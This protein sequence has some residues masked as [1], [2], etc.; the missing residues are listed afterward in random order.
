MNLTLKEV[1]VS[2][3]LWLFCDLM[4]LQI[5]DHTWL[6]NSLIISNQLWNIHRNYIKKSFYKEHPKSINLHH[7]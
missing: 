1:F 6:K 5:W 2:N 7:A 3:V 4:R